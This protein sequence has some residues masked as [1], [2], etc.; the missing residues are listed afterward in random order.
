MKNK[1]SIYSF[2]ISVALI[3]GGCKGPQG[4]VGPAGVSGTA[5]KN[6][7][8]GTTGTAGSTGAT[9]ATGDTGATGTT[10]ATGA[11]G[12]TG[13]TGTKGDPGSLTLVYSDWKLLNKFV[14]NADLSNTFQYLDNT[15]NNY[16]A[17]VPNGLSVSLF[18][19][20]GYHTVTN[21][22]GDLVGFLYTYYK[23]TENFVDV[24]FPGSYTREPVNVTTNSFGGN[25]SVPALS[26]NVYFYF[27]KSTFT[28]K[29]DFAKEITDRKPSARLLFLPLA[30]KK[31]RMAHVDMSNYEEVKRT[32]N[33]R[34]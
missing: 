19:D 3:L 30:L 5:G 12:D 22:S 26:S 11:G 28:D 23:I 29:S 18:R 34:D 15:S 16:S 9:G 4:D 14:K 8:N 2:I 27:N 7:T 21:G 32:F 31:G 24:V 10:G 20:Y 13:A 1:I 6:G 33:L 25:S 17:L